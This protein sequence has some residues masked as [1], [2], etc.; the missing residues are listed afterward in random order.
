MIRSA[1]ASIIANL[2]GDVA[3]GARELATRYEAILPFLQGASLILCAFFVFGAVYSIAQSR[4]HHLVS[5]KWLDRFGSKAALARRMRRLWNDAMRDIQS[6]TDRDKWASAMRNAEDVLQEGLKV[7]GYRALSAGE[8]MRMAV[9]ANKLETIG[10]MRAA[11]EAYEEAKGEA[12]SLTHRM[13]IEA[14]KKYKRAIRE[15][16][17]MGEGKF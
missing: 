12:A 5:D 15:L 14:L 2:E 13:A 16:G 8:R 11:H 1:L 9:D 7:R 17:V 3:Q 4:Y 6:R 10:D